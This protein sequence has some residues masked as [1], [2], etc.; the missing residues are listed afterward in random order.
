M[1]ASGL[2]WGGV[3][4]RST[5]GQATADLRSVI[6]TAHEAFISMDAGGFI[7]DWNPE[8]ERTFGWSRTEA[9]GAILADL[10]IPPSYR[11]AHWGGLKRFLD[12][13]EGPV[14]GKRL[15][16]TALH[17]EG[18]EFPVEMTISAVP[19]D[20][21]H[22]FHAFLHDISERKRDERYTTAYHAVTKALAEA[23]SFDD[24][25]RRLL[26]ALAESLEWELGGWWEAHDQEGVMH[27]R[28]LWLAPGLRAGSFESLSREVAFQRGEG[29]PGRVWESGEPAWIDD[30]RE[31]PNFPRAPAAAE[32]GL[33]AA[34]CIPLLS[35]SRLR[36]AIEFFTR[37]ARHR[38]ER[39]VELLDGLSAQI[40]AFLAVLEE[41][42]EALEKLESLALTDEL[43]GL[44]NRRAWEQGLTREV[45]RVAREKGHLWVAMLDLDHFKAFNDERG[46]QAGDD[47]LEN[48]AD[49]WRGMIR[50]T[51]LLSRY[52]GEEFALAFP[53][54]P[55]EI[56]HAVVERLR[57]AVPE[58]QS[59]SAG[60]AVW[61][62]SESAD[63]LVARADAA[64][65]QAK[66]EGRDRT[67][68]AD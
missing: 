7:T 19:V 39:F 32:A 10:I 51:D 56:A 26:P 54:W 33:H 18:Y 2:G 22:S 68:L 15:E 40:G 57:A 30:V 3:S 1:G 14:L 11:E 48:T 46:H 4:E 61:N 28:D 64:L 25:A 66:R 67:V 41:R 62:G 38:D 59:C 43:T 8:A 20:A 49:A 63:E 21:L 29:L 45:A 27:C 13:G 47:L 9:I 36:G 55:Q 58:G 23:S 34:V 50:T 52:G 6:D 65:Y 60:L 5:R 31:D 53:A 17:R 16:L 37:E 44:A 42:T 24:A 35:G 12:T